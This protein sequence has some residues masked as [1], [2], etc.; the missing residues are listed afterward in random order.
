MSKLNGKWINKDAENLTHSGDDL[1]VQFSDSSA[2]DDNKVWSS[3]KINTISGTLS[4]ELNAAWAAGDVILDTKIDTTSGTLQAAIDAVGG[5]D[6]IEYITLD[7]TDITNKYV[8]L[9][10][11]PFSATEVM[12]DIIGGGPQLYTTDFA[13]TTN[14]LDWDGLGLDGVL[15]AADKLRISYTY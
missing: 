12:L 14:Q 3:D 1:A 11:T 7:G 4:T 15:E 10:Q 5:V 6:E 9:A 8:T 13:V 2:P